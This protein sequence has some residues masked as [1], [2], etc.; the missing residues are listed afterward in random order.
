MTMDKENGPL[1]GITVLDFSWVLT[2]PYAT[3]TLCDLGAEVIKLERYKEGSAERHFP[4]EL[5]ENKVT[6]STYDIFCNRGKKSI[7][8]NVKNPKGKQTTYDLIKKSDIIIENFAPGTMDRIGLGYEN[9]K[10]INEKIIYCSISCFGQYG[11]YRNKPGFD[12]IAQAASGWTSGN[13]NPQAAPS[14]IADTVAGIHSTTAIL[15]ALYA[16]EKFGIGQYIDIAMTDCLFGLQ[17][18][19]IPFYSISKS[20]GKPVELGKVGR[21]TDGYAPYGIF[22]GKNGS[23]NIA[24]ITPST[25]ERLLKAMGKEHLLGDERVNTVA[26]RCANGPYINKIIEDWIAEQ[27]TVEKAEEILTEHN[28]PC[29]R[30]KSHKELIDSDPNIAARNMLV[31]IDQPFMGKIKVTGSSIKM[32]ETECKVRGHSPLLGEN[33]EEI[34][35]DLLGYSE[36]KIKDLYES[37]AIY[38]SDV[39]AMLNKKNEVR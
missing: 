39:A 6:Q 9:A 17:E 24:A 5:H 25:F 13:K 15:A 19:A 21:F 36:E 20:I 38:Q 31:D 26:A 37:E 34:F 10:K 33:N 29:M 3:R 16:R 18:S 30:A 22:N 14:A 1:Q 28:V 11:P 4:L 27:G 12:I 32:S 8:V 23:I 7:C 2:G 35:R